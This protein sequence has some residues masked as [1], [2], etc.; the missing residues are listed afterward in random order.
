MLRGIQKN[1]VDVNKRI[2]ERANL[3]QTLQAPGEAQGAS[4]ALTSLDP[5]AAGSRELLGRGEEVT[6]RARRAQMGS[7]MTDEHYKAQPEKAD[8]NTISSIHPHEMSELAPREH[9]ADP[10]GTL[11]PHHDAS[12]METMPAAHSNLLAAPLVPPKPSHMTATLNHL[13]GSPDPKARMRNDIKRVAQLYR[14]G[15]PSTGGHTAGQTGPP[16]ISLSKS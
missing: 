6:L 14:Q 2:M 16:S 4:K 12:A 3:L 15:L 8:L 1:W 13:G 10:L 11:L 7:L 9:E 5:V